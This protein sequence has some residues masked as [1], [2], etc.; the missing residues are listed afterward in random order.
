MGPGDTPEF[1]ASDGAGPHVRPSNG[2]VMDAIE[3]RGL[4]IA[5]ERQGTGPPLVLLHGFVGHSQ[6]WRRQIDGLSDVY[7][8]VAW[9]APGAGRSTDPPEMF[10]LP[11]YADCLAA[12]IDALGLL[13]PHVVGL[14]FGG[15]LALELY[16]RHPTIPKSLVLASA[17]AGWAGSLSDE[18]TEQ[19]LRATLQAAEAPADQRVQ[20]MIPGMFSSSPPAESVE[21][22]RGIMVEIHPAGL[23]AMARSLAEADLRDVLPRIT[24][25]TLL[26]YGDHDGRASL[27]V[28]EDIHSRIP[29]SRLV[30]MPGVG[31]MSSVEAA[32]RFNEEVRGFLTST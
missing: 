2:D 21:E 13:R 20:S 15:A 25:P 3:A 30:V 7:T 31:H 24:V 17:Y 1:G 4:K 29:A 14:S 12:F 6:E 28:A 27:A 5:F 22:F 9:D 26:L 18:V 16:R 19:R 23:R 32:E 10:R 11:D 8:V